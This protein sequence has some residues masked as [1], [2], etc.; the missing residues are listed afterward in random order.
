MSL[1][2]P[3][4]LIYDY[5]DYKMIIINIYNPQ[6]YFQLW[7]LKLSRNFKKSYSLFY[8]ELGQKDV[9]VGQYFNIFLEFADQRKWFKSVFEN[10]EKFYFCIKETESKECRDKSKLVSH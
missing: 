10:F 7:E 1:K 4:E 8:T 9:S 2:N 3:R 5:F 6:I